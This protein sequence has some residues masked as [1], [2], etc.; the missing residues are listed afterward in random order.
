MKTAYHIVYFVLPL[1][2]AAGACSEH[3][4]PESQDQPVA[5]HDSPIVVDMPGTKGVD[6]LTTAT[7]VD[8]DM[9]AIWNFNGTSANTWYLKQEKVTKSGAVEPMDRIDFAA[10]LPLQQLHEIRRPARRAM[11]K[12]PGR[13]DAAKNAVVFI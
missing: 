9:S 3:N 12:Q 13:L 11:R 6:P 2:L 1:L 10:G 8:F 4:G 7:L 5:D